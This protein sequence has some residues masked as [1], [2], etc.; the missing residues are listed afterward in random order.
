[1]T[2]EPRRVAIIGGGIAGMSAALSLATQAKRWTI[3]VHESKRCTGGRAGSF[4]DVKTGDNVDYCQHVAMACCTNLLTMLRDAGI[5]QWYT[6]YDSLTFHH[7]DYPPS[8]FAKSNW[9]PAPFHLLPTLASIHYLSWKQKAEIAQATFRLM[10]TKPASLR[11]VHAR[12]WLTSV[13]QSDST[14][15]DYWEIVL[16]SAL[17]DT[18]ERVSMAAARKVFI[19]GFLATKSASD[20]LVP[21]LPLATL[22][23][24]RLPAVLRDRGVN[25]FTASR[26]SNIKQHDDQ[27]FAV[28]IDDSVLHYD[29]V[30]VALPAHGL[31]KIFSPS[32]ADAAGINTDAF[33]NVPYSPITGVHLWFDRPVM[34]DAHAVMVGT[35]A[36]WLFRRETSGSPSD[37]KNETT[38]VSH[39]VQVVISASHLLK[40]QE[41]SQVVAQVTSEIKQLFPLARD[42]SLLTSRVVTDP[43]S[44]Y[45]LSPSVDSI[46][47]ASVTRLPGLSLAGD[48][49]QTGWPATMEGAVISGRMAANDV[50]TRFGCIPVPIDTLSQKS[51]ASRLLIR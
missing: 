12:Q 47:P 9:L 46:R 5:P 8:K 11:A 18:C 21:K 51:L 38:D 17:G 28:R 25:V 31:A 49:V 2:D 41:A 20:V 32:I 26:V 19:D 48:F 23:G 33:A 42:A 34:P 4:L 40:G 6:R 16:A 37:A 3:D 50:L 10:R 24:D 30:I 44:V 35:L 15:R 27:T 36:Q 22:F 39:Y 29:H 13:G 14:I 45:S 1:M 7:P 43:Q